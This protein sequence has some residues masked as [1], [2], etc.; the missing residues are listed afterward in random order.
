MFCLEKHCVEN[1]LLDNRF[2][3]K[4]NGLNVGDIL[5]FIKGATF[6]GFFV[7]FFFKLPMKIL[8]SGKVFFKHF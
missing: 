6:Y 3:R 7:H 2:N 8:E 4:F 5:T 1:I